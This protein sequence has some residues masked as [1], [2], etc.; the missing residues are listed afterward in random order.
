MN[1]CNA[2]QSIYHRRQ[3]QQF[4]EQSDF[5]EI[6]HGIR[7]NLEVLQVQ[8]DS[9]MT[10]LGKLHHNPVKPEQC[11]CDLHKIR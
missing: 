8:L 10:K 9:Y 3:G 2:C 4:I 11:A 5:E 6:I 7:N 1:S